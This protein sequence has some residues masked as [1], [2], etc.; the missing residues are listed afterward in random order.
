MSGEQVQEITQEQAAAATATL[1][2]RQKNPE[3]NAKLVS[4]TDGADV[5]REFKALME[6]SSKD[7]AKGGD[8]LDRIVAGVEP[9]PKSE[10]TTGG[11][12]STAAALEI[13]ASLQQAGLTAEQ[14]RQAMS[15]KPVPKA[16][17]DAIMVLRG[18]L[19]GNKEWVAKLT[20]GDAKARRE[21]LL[22]STVKANGWIGQEWRP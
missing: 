20:S 10:T 14:T 13:A 11:Q 17:Y 18:D 1:V 9:I 15:G 4:T 6:A 16:E 22:F 3:W 19:L 12:I 8:R 5:K 7:T 21:L 2:E